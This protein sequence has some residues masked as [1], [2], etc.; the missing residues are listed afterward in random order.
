MTYAGVLLLDIF[1][2]LPGNIT[3]NGDVSYMNKCSKKVIQV[4]VLIFCLLCLAGCAGLKI[5]ADRANYPYIDSVSVSTE[6]KAIVVQWKAPLFGKVKKI[7]IV[8]TGNDKQEEVFLPAYIGRYSFT[9]GEAGTVYRVYVTG[10][11]SDGTYGEIISCDRM[12]LDYDDIPDIPFINLRTN[13]G[14]DPGY[15]E[16]ESAKED[17]ALVIGRTIE[18]NDYVEG[19]F[20]MEENRYETKSSVMKIKVR[21]N[22]SALDYDKKPYKIL[23]DNA[24]D[25]LDLGDEYA[26][27]EWILLN[28][29]ENLKTWLGTYVSEYC[30]MEWQPKVRFVNLMLN[31][32]YK[33]MYLLTESVERGENKCNISKNGFLIEYDLYWWKPG[34]VYFKTRKQNKFMAYTLKYPTAESFDDER[35]IQIN[36]YMQNI[37][38]MLI[39]YDPAVFD[40]IDVDSF[41]GWTLIKDIL[42]VADDNGSNMFFYLYDMDGG[43]PP[44]YKLKMGPAWDFD[45]MFETDEFE[46]SSQH[47]WVGNFTDYL[48]NYEEFRIAYANAWIAVKDTLRADI[49]SY[50]DELCETKG[51]AINESRRLDSERWRHDVITVEDEAENIDKWLLKHM[52]WIESMFRG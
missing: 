17:A 38:D 22:T 48:W 2:I 4:T 6:D 28:T 15:T 32:D 36:A 44:Q 13:N 7:R 11:Y 24:L 14:E 31:G 43:Q 47:Y 30:G 34:E 26:E 10:K 3:E 18:D 8:I 40:Y 51:D 45:S 9:G 49:E 41:A 37:E 20:S 39:N 12:F 52:W 50:I 27:K 19:V 42:G 25:L 21:G 23:L 5:Y 46:W 1:V 33:G 29:G 16:S 35:V